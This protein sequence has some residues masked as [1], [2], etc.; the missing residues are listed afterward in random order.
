MGIWPCTACFSPSAAEPEDEAGETSSSISLTIPG[1]SWQR[2]KP[3]PSSIAILT[4]LGEAVTKPAG[5]KLSGL[6]PEFKYRW[7]DRSRVKR[8]VEG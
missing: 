2:R 5:R 7:N 8:S 3:Y 1:V 6:H 4:D